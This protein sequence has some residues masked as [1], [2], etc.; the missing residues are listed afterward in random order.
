ML[1]GWERA[2]RNSG[3]RILEGAGFGEGTDEGSWALGEAGVE[4]GAAL[5]G[6]WGEVGAAGPVGCPEGAK[7]LI[8]FLHGG[9]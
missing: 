5:P 3:P 6:A 8:R 2:I 9:G 4:G 7:V 1:E